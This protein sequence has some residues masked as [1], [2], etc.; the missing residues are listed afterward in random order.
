MGQFIE[1]MAQD[2]IFQITLLDTWGLESDKSYTENV[3]FE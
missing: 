1:K 2:K 3:H